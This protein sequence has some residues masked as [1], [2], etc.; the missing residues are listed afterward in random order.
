MLSIKIKNKA[1]TKVEHLY[2]DVWKTA[3]Q[4]YFGK[5]INWSTTKKIVEAYDK[6]NLVGVIELHMQVGVMYIFELAVAYSHQKQGIGRMLIEKAEELARKE[7]M[8]KIHLDTGKTWGTAK[9][10]EKMGFTKTGEFP[11]HFAGQD[12]LQYSKFL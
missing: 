5:Q 4:E 6:K 2:K 11:K 9:F 8:H 1:S 10:Y 12:Y 7:K 3:N